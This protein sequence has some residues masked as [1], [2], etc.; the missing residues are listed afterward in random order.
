MQNSKEYVWKTSFL[1]WFC[2][3]KKEISVCKWMATG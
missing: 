2:T 1:F 3:E